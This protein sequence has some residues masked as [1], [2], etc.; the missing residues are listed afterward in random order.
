MRTGA[1][2]EKRQEFDQLPAIIAVQVKIKTKYLELNQLP[3]KTG[4][5]SENNDEYPEL[6][7]M[8]M[9]ISI[10][11]WNEDQKYHSCTYVAVHSVVRS[12]IAELIRLSSRTLLPLEE[13]AVSVVNHTEK[14]GSVSVTNCTTF[15]K[16]L[17][18][19]SVCH[20]GSH[21][22]SLLWY[23][24]V[25]ATTLAYLLQCVY[26]YDCNLWTIY[27]MQIIMWLS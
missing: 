13:F 11:S 4:I 23:W 7:E 21:M 19:E 18:L 16:G 9:K 2:N 12:N 14:A 25:G 20:T 5:A 1:A 26:S 15:I 8:P 27:V 22:C 10:A 3:M 6:N 17:H 24:G